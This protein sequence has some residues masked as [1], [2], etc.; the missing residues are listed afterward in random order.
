MS[1]LSLTL[2]EHKLNP[3]SLSNWSPNIII[4]APPVGHCH[5]IG[6]LG[7]QC[8]DP[9][10][11]SFQD[12]LTTTLFGLDHAD[13]DI[14]KDTRMKID[15]A[16][17]LRELKSELLQLAKI[18]AIDIFHFLPFSGTVGQTLPKKRPFCEEKSVVPGPS[19]SRSVSWLLRF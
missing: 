9:K 18:H 16:R 4:W 3:R 2:S 7:S 1:R 15:S 13:L 8:L 17:L 5:S 19:S 11:S 12:S 10:L 6:P 14:N